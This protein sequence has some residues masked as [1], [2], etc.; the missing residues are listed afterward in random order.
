MQLNNE[1]ERIQG[2]L[3]AHGIMQVDV[4]LFLKS[5]EATQPLKSSIT[6]LSSLVAETFEISDAWISGHSNCVTPLI[7]SENSFSTW[8]QY[9]LNAKRHGFKPKV[10][11]IKNEKNTGIEKKEKNDIVLVVAL[12]KVIKNGMGFTTYKQWEA[13]IAAKALQLCEKIGFCYQGICIEERE[14]QKLRKNEILP[15]LALQHPT[16][17]WFPEQE[18]I[19]L[20]NKGEGE[21]D[22]KAHEMLISQLCYTEILPTYLINPHPSPLPKLGE[23]T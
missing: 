9:L 12:H 14:F 23:G 18:N 8:V 11:F 1:F 13:S 22:L 7:E 15:V 2:I 16:G 21:E 4:P 3:L 17:L 6:T 10:L 19:L 5:L 20:E